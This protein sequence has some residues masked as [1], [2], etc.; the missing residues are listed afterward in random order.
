VLIYVFNVFLLKVSEQKKISKII[1]ITRLDGMQSVISIWAKH[2]N[3]FHILK[4]FIFLFS[5]CVFYYTEFIHMVDLSRLWLSSWGLICFLATTDFL[6]TWLFNFL[7]LS[8]PD[9]G[10]SRSVSCSRKSTFLIKRITHCY[11]FF[12]QKCT[13]QKFGL[14]LWNLHECVIRNLIHQIVSHEI[15]SPIKTLVNKWPTK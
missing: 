4:H 3:S 8:V 14:P 9:E 6:A 12:F 15:Q 7:S 2:E 1:D 10:Y 13:L 5:V 11:L